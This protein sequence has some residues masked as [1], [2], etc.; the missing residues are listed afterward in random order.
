MPEEKGYF[1]HFVGFLEIVVWEYEDNTTENEG[2][3]ENV[4]EGL[5]Y[6]ISPDGAYYILT[7][8]GSFTG[9]ELIVPI[10][11]D[12]LPVK[13]IATDAFWRNSTITSVRIPDGVTIRE[14]AFNNMQKIESVIIGRYAIIEQYAF[15]NCYT[16]KS[17]KVGAYAQASD[18]MFSE[19]RALE[20]AEFG[21]GAKFGGYVFYGCKALTEFVIPD[22]T[23]SIGKQFFDGC[24][25]LVTVT[26]PK[27]L[28]FIGSLAFDD[29]TSL[30]V[31]YK[32]SETCFKIIYTQSTSTMWNN[33]TV[34]Y[35]YGTDSGS[36]KA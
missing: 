24:P 16:L 29:C 31:N 32:G 2:Y 7:G 23:V 17:A 30:T 18:G 9:S 26:I 1:W 6:K 35:D 33:V 36:E 20:V 13:E 19:C 8:I 22:G 15:Q 27:T 25:A 12:G 3:P 11:H 14:T 10:Y 21:Y 5:D 34:N 4:S 28:Q